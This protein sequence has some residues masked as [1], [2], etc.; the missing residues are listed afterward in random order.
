MDKKDRPE[1]TGKKPSAKKKTEP[2]KSVSTKGVKK[3]ALK[4][5]GKPTTKAAKAKAKKAT[6]AKKPKVSSKDLLLKKFDIGVVPEMAAPP[7]AEPAA[8]IPD[9]PPFVTGYDKNETKRIRV[10][11][12]KEFDLAAVPLVKEDQTETIKKAA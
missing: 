4:K 11:L 3:K 12:F 7:K 5:K 10:L 2:K 8:K 9:P 1:S 6:A